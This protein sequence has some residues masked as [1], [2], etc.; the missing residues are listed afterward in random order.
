MASDSLEFSVGDV[1][2]RKS[3]GPTMTVVQAMDGPLTL[4]ECS[5]FDGENVQ[6]KVF[7]GESLLVA[8]DPYA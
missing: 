5:W 1:V 7:P 2:V 8:A 3:G 6:S 4:Y